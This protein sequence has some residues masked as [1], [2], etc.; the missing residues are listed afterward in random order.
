[1]TNDAEVENVIKDWCRA[2]GRGKDE[3][4]RKRVFKKTMRKLKDIAK[5]WKRKRKM[6]CYDIEYV[7]DFA[8]DECVF[9]GSECRKS[10]FLFE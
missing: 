5:Y 10:D 4:Y 2:R 1:M 9:K 6:G 3:R 8:L 7:V